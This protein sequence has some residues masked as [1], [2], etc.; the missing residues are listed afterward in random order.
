M[1][2]NYFLLI[3]LFSI[4]LFVTTISTTEAFAATTAYSMKWDDRVESVLDDYIQTELM[5]NEN[6]RH[7]TIK[8]RISPT[9]DDP[10]APKYYVRILYDEIFCLPS[11]IMFGQFGEPI[12]GKET[13]TS[14]ICEKA[15]SKTD[16]A[17]TDLNSNQTDS[18]RMG[19]IGSPYI[20]DVNPVQVEN[21][22]HADLI[23]RVDFTEIPGKLDPIHGGIY[24]PPNKIYKHSDEVDTEIT[25][26]LKDIMCREGFD[27]EIRDSNG[28][29]VCIKSES[30]KKLLDR[31]FLTHGH[32]L[33]LY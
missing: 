13:P 20:G 14:Y 4:T 3:G 15:P 8:T 25:S 27:R 32:Y 5:T 1:N 19:S 31:G 26:Q 7:D 11:N 21:I 12:I 16:L 22:F 30:F 23:F 24:L 29:Y 2:K 33:T 9:F 10:L 28:K 6:I 18:F 17:W